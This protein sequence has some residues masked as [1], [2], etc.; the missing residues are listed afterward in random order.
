LLLRHVRHSIGN[1]RCILLLTAM[2]YMYTYPTDNLDY[3]PRRNG[4]RVL[5]ALDSTGRALPVS[6]TQ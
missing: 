1:A 4:I 6:M 2:M 3:F 5:I